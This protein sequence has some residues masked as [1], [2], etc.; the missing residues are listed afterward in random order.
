MID[1]DET[2]DCEALGCGRKFSSYEELLDH[3]NRRH[4]I[5]YE[6]YTKNDLFIQIDD[7]I[8]QIEKDI[9]ENEIPEVKFVYKLNETFTDSLCE[10]TTS[11]NEQKVRI[12]TEEM[13]GMGSKYKYLDE[14]E[15]VKYKI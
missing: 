1:L 11:Q 3:Y 4:P 13:I 2:Y 6:R 14:I 7:K 10:S 15:D 8:N 12:V 5:L 9:K